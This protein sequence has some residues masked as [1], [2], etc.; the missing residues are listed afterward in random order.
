MSSARQS[1]HVIVESLYNAGV[2]LV[3]GIPGAKVD[4]IFN[5]L[6]DH[7]EIHLVICRHEQNAVIT[8]NSF[9][10]NVEVVNHPIRHLWLPLLAA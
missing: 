4:S 6:L 7:P 2:R 8:W 9:V 1:S 10:K 3:F 5:I